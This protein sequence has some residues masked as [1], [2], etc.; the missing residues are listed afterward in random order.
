[1]FF[2]F[3]KIRGYRGSSL[4]WLTLLSNI[5][6]SRSNINRIFAW[7]FLFLFFHMHC[8]ASTSDIW[9]IGKALAPHPRQQL[10]YIWIYTCIHVVLRTNP[11]QRSTLP[12]VSAWPPNWIF[13]SQMFLI[14]LPYNAQ[15]RNTLPLCASLCAVFFRAFRAPLLVDGY[16]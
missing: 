13:L 4:P 1:M 11:M 6:P 9:W 10:A 3:N 12:G 14:R 7:F 2:F 8:I 16:W 5:Y 15:Y